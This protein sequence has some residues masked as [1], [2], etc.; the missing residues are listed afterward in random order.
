MPPSPKSG[1]SAPALEKGLDILELLAAEGRPMSTRQVAERLGRS[2]NEIFRMVHVL[3]GRGYIARGAANDSLVV[4]N[5]LFSLGIQT[6]LTRDL[7][8]V[9]APA[10]TLLAEEIQQS[11]HLVVA[12][13]GQ[14]V[15]IAS[16][17]G[18]AD[19]NFSLKLGYR[20]PLVDA[21]SGLLLMA[22]QPEALRERMIAE[23]L[24]LL[25][26]KADRRAL[27]AELAGL[28][29]QGHII[30]DSRDIVGI[31]DI[32]APVALSDGRAIAVLLVAHLNRRTAPA[33]YRSTLRRLKEACADI[34]GQLEQ[35]RADQPP[36]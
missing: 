22:F 19:M 10:V 5:K 13:R 9:A 7:V 11:V 14:T 33:D 3:L 29:R 23:S 4:T 15:V 25:A 6:A 12:N 32:A 16:A 30:R 8:A 28:A 18:S 17:S 31:T 36:S 21:H 34:A 27:E 24:A 1:Y 26:R 20:R 35:Y 2:K